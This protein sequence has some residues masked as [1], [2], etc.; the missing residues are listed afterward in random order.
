MSREMMC[1]QAAALVVVMVSFVTSRLKRKRSRPD[2]EPD[3]LVYALRDEADQHKE[4]TLNLIYNSNDG[5]G[6]SMLRMTRA[7]F[8]ALCNLFRDRS[9]VS[10]RDGVTVEEQVAMFLHVV[11]RNQRFRVVHQ[12]FRRSIEIVHR[13]FHQVLYAV[14]ELRSEMIK[15]RDEGH[16]WPFYGHWYICTRF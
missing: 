15:P 5:E 4:Q 8:F 9:L 2:T 14:G 3:P 1:R 16:L 12:S 10:D 7:P 6:L 13:H 11:G